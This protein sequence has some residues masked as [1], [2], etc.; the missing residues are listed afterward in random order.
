MS[1]IIKRVLTVVVALGLL[2]SASGAQ[3]EEIDSAAAIENLLQISDSLQAEVGK[4]LKDRDIE[5]LRTILPEDLG[6][7]LTGGTAVAGHDATHKYGELLMDTFGGGD[8]KTKRERSGWMP[9]TAGYSQELCA[10]EF[11]RLAADST[12]QKWTGHMTIYWLYQEGRW[13]LKRLY[14]SKR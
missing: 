11:T 13:N 5:A 1:G 7:V 9:K 3:D 10:F 6:I 2:A 4:A 12:T 8:L 14:L